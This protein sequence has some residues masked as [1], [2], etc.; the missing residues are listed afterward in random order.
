MHHP[1]ERTEGLHVG[2]SRRGG[3][4]LFAGSP[5]AEGAL[6]TSATLL[7]LPTH[8]TPDI[9]RGLLRH[10]VFDWTPEDG[11]TQYAVALG[12][13]SLC[14]HSPRPNCRFEID[15]ER[16]VIRLYALRPIAAGE[17]LTIDYAYDEFPFPI[18]E[19]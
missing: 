4:G 18:V 16:H 6:V 17:E 8:E 3:R 2:P 19:K 11:A 9:D 1:L 7:V 10:Y 15:R 12:E 5:L 13:I 14:N